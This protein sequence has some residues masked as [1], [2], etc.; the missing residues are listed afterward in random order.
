MPP[1]DHSGGGG[2]EKRTVGQNEF[3]IVFQLSRTELF[4]VRYCTLGN[5]DHPGL[6]ISAARVSNDKQGF[7]TYG[8]VQSRVL[9]D[10]PAASKFHQKWAILYGQELDAAQYKELR[11]SNKYLKRQYNFYEVKLSNTHHVYEPSIEFQMLARLCEQPV[12][13]S[14]A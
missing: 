4:Q 12:K 11:Q 9:A 7:A 6:Y 1:L 14:G 2:E 10:Y 3:I 8:Q 13:R 5:H